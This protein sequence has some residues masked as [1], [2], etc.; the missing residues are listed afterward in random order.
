MILKKYAKVKMEFYKINKKGS[1]SK[2]TL[3][4]I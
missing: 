1:I 4:I 2:E 3:F